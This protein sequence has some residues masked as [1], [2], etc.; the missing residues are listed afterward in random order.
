MPELSELEMR[1]LSELEEA[2]EEDVVTMMLTV[3][4]PTGERRDVEE[5]QSALE[6]LVRLDLI[7]MSMDRDASGRLRDLSRTDSLEVVADLRSRLRFDSTKATWVIAQC[8]GPP[9]G[10][11]FPYIVNTKAGKREGFEILNQRGYQ[12]WRPKR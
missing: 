6:S 4:E 10:D 8:S 12:W 11:A 1:I 3:A 7:R 5:M 2:G 9:F